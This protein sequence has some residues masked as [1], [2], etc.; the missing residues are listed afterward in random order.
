MAISLKIK[1]GTRAQLTAA[2][3]SG[4]LIAGEPYLVTDEGRFAIGLSGSSFETFAKQS[5]VGA[6]GN[7]SLD[8][9]LISSQPSSSADYGS[10][11]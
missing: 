8:Y 10:I 6:G 5:E 4:T 11:L 9:G 1:R 2:A 7:I 3:G